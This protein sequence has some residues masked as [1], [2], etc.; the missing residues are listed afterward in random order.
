VDVVIGRRFRARSPENVVGEIERWYKKGFKDFSFNDSTFTEVMPRAEKIADEL[1][2]RGIDIEWD[3]R[4][5][6]R[7]DRVNKKLL[8]RLKE[9]GCR[10]VLFGIE[11]IDRDVLKLMRKDIDFKQVEK[12]LLDAKSCGLGV[13][14]SF[15][16]GTPGD[17]LDKFNK[18]Y[19]FANSDIFDEV[20]FYN[21]EPYPGTE[22]YEWIEKNATLLIKPEE[23]LNSRS[24]W[25]EEP[26]YETKDFSRKQRK[27]A[28]N[29]GEFLVA[30]KLITKV[31]GN[32]MLSRIFYIPCR[33]RWLRKAILFL[34]FKIGPRIFKFK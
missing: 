34:G 26:I 30:K 15:M 12:A 31:L 2:K 19:D 18:A 6:I 28:F 27:M 17:T 32:G 3:L 9:A 29:K 16:I 5:G 21:T 7:V 20:R 23:Y 22:L 25:D 10:F 24:R 1:I 14:G 8:C 33:I 13:G 4:T 11:S